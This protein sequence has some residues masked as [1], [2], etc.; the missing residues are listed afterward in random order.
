MRYFIGLVLALALGVIGCGETSGTGG[1]AGMGGGGVGGD[2]SRPSEFAAGDAVWVSGPSPY[3]ECEDDALP[4]DPFF[5]DSEVE[6]WLAVNPTNPDHMAA[7]WQQDRYASGACRGNVVSVS[8]DG[9][10]S[11]QESLLPKLTPCTGGTWAKA[12][13]PWVTFAA[14]GDLYLSLI[15]I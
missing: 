3:A 14:N 13:D 9:G 12:S 10:E 4:D 15:H 11:W 8:F 1:A 2:P 5:A 6:P 7:A